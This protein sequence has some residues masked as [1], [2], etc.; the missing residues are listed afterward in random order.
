MPYEG[1]AFQKKV[2]NIQK[3]NN[4][5]LKTYGFDHS[6]PHSLATQL[7]Y[8]DG[9]PDKLFVTGLNT[10]KSYSKF[11]GWPIQ[12]IE[13]TYPLR[14]KNLKKNS[15]SNK[16]FLPYDFNH[17]EEILYNFNFFLN[18][19]SNKSLSDFLILIHPE[20]KNDTRHIK[21]KEK[22][23]KI[24]SNNKIKF[25]KKITTSL[26]IVV[27]F[28][29]TPLVALEFKSSVL[30]ICPNPSFD[31]Y[32]NYFWPNIKIKKINRHCYIYRFDKSGKYLN[33]NSSDKIK[34]IIN[35]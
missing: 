19:K 12:N 6:A 33:F 22:L 28:T 23:E 4:N 32:L 14:Y 31:I 3:K 18:K 16:M 8:T 35:E 7:Y 13:V 11:Y 1:Q 9:S 34:K 17:E 25:S 20:K 2:F 21:L 5:N 10:K 27:G 24:K 26:T 29:T 30:H 15:F